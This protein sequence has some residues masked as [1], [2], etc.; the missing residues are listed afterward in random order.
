MV[1]TEVKEV[2][3]RLLK[4]IVCFLTGGFANRRKG[5]RKDEAC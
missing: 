3:L 1:K 5:G 2:I 4:C